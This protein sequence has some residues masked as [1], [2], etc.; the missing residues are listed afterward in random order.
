ML[1][2]AIQIEGKWYQK[3]GSIQRSDFFSCYLHLFKRYTF[4]KLKQQQYY[5][6]MGVI[7]YM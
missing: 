7:K 4:L 1:K 6:I 5:V 2:E 3:Y